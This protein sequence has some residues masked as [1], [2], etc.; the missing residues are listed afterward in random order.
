MT[1]Y[2]ARFK[3]AAQERT[4]TNSS[5]RP[6]TALLNT[7][8]VAEWLGINKHTLL[9]WRVEGKPSPP[10]IKIGGELRFKIEDVQAWIDSNAEGVRR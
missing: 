7:Q 8:Q 10:A 9:V 2:S 1:T 6:F 4:M 3:V 5:V